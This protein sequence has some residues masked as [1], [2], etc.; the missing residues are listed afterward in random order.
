MTRNHD[1]TRAGLLAAFDLVR[2]RDALTLVGS[3]ELVGERV[4]ADAACVDN[5]FRGEDVLRSGLDRKG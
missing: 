5:G 4:V 1:R 3:A 2:G